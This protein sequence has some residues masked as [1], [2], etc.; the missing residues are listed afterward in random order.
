LLLNVGLIA[1]GKAN[2]VLTQENINR[3]YRK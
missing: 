2:D 1:F 3:T